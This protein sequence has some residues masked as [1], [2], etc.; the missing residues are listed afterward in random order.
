MAG[1]EALNP[2]I[3]VVI[4][5]YNEQ[6]NAAAIAAAVI[7]V[8]ETVSDSF[9]LIFID[10]ASSDETVPIIRALANRDPRIRLIVNTRN[11]GQMRSP[12]HALFTARGRAVIGICA[13]FQDPPELLASFVTRWRAGADIVLGTRESEKSSLAVGLFRKLAYEF[14]RRFGDYP[15]V[16]NAT[17]FGLYDRKA[18][19]AIA[20]M[21]EPEPFF[22]GMLVE[23]GYTI[24]TIPY[25]RPTRSKGRSSNTFFTLLDFALSSLASFSKKLVRLPFFFGIMLGIVAGAMLVAAPIALLLGGRMMPWLVAAGIELQFA[26]LFVFLGLIG[27]QLRLNGERT[28]QTPLVFERERVNFPEGY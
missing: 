14:A 3:T 25:A 21:K 9:D 7:A 23:T 27:D 18:V 16:P 11:F 6:E 2:E 10:N 28:R 15:I 26:L 17:G 13:D 8:M 19:R 22:R 12:T 20:A 4:P 24:E 5:C 1:S